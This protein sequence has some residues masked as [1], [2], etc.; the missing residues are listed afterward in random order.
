MNIL[1]VFSAFFDPTKGGVQRL[2]T[3]LFKSLIQRGVDV[4]FLVLDDGLGWKEK[5]EEYEGKRNGKNSSFEPTNDWDEVGISLT[6]RVL[7]RTYFLPESEGFFTEKN[8]EYGS[9]VMRKIGVTH[10]INQADLFSKVVEWMGG[11]NMRMERKIPLISVHHN[12]VGCLAKNYRE[13]RFGGRVQ[14]DKL[15]GKGGGWS[16]ESIQFALMDR[17]WVWRIT[18]YLVKRKYARYFSHVIDQSDLYVVY[19]DTFKEELIDFGVNNASK[20]RVIP[21]PA[22]F[23]IVSENE[24]NKENR[25]AFIARVDHGQKR[26]DKAIRL[27]ARLHDEYPD[28][29]FDVVGDGEAL[30]ELK[31]FAKLKSLDRVFFH[32]FQDPIEY[33]KRSKV[34]IMTS[35]FEGFGLTLIESQALGAVPVVYNCFS[36]IHEVVTIKSGIVVEFGDDIGFEKA[37]K[38]LMENEQLRRELMIGGFQNAQRFDAQAIGLKWIEL[39]ES[40]PSQN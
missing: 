25:V 17:K 29:E 2:T 6:E 1:F 33:F 11:V 12:C 28:W 18:E 9:E 7:G 5:K 8:I 27:F 31:E 32:G 26:P 4:H 34:F 36:S 23:N 24:L 22:S 3:I 20:I 39:L 30:E 19:F 10:V 38:Q 37:V 15:N 21:N 35:D 40:I 13:I 16:L 14:K